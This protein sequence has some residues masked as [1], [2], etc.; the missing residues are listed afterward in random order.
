MVVRKLDWDHD[1]ISLR[2]KETPENPWQ[3]VLEKYPHGSIH[4]GKVSRLA[5]FGAFV[6][7]EPGV[8]GLLHISR[9]GDGRK[10][11]HLRKAVEIGQE[12][13]VRENPLT[14]KSSG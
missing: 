4:R 5:Q 7:L 8:D 11:H 10:L 14:G 2:L 1:R 6:T 9:L 13:T 3:N 12:I